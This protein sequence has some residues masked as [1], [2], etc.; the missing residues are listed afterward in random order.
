MR[1]IPREGFS[2]YVW[3]VA[4][5]AG[6][7]GLSTL[8]AE[9][10]TGISCTVGDE[11]ACFRTTLTVPSPYHAIG[12]VSVISAIVLLLYAMLRKRE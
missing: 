5:L 11:I 1:R 3:G 2:L 12:I 6:G 9:V 4:L 8:P 10:T 7:L